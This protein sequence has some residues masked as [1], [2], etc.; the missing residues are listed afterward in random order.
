M[1]CTWLTEMYLHTL[2]ELQHAPPAEQRAAA[3]EFADFMTDKFRH[4]NPAATYA[5]LEAHGG[6]Q[7]VEH[8]AFRTR[9][10]PSEPEHLPQNPSALRESEHTSSERP[11]VDGTTPACAQPS[12]A[13]WPARAPSPTR[14]DSSAATAAPAARK[15]P[16]SPAMPRECAS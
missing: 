16:T 8:Y 3:A 5:L 9:A 12:P 11:S 14:R 10:P 7:E 1:L 2:G 4:L 6:T 13:A 15:A